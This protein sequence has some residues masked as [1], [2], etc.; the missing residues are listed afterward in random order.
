[1][2]T[3]LIIE[4]DKVIRENTMELLEFSNYKVV[5][6]KNGKDGVKLA[7]D[8]MP[9]LVLCDI[10][11][12]MLCGYQVLKQLARNKKTASI[13][14]I[15]FSAKCDKADIRKGMNLGADDYITK[16][17]SEEDLLEAIKSR[18]AKF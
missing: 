5:T 13:P 1:M 17:F 6:A 4:G 12:P 14:F 16:P 10:I 8:L 7:Y 15:F 2:R 18:L 9:D 11:M 3:I